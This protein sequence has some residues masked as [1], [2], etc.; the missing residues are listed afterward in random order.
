MEAAMEQAA[1]RPDKRMLR[2]RRDIDPT[3]EER[4]VVDACARAFG[5]R[6]DLLRR[7]GCGSPALQARIACYRILRRSLGLSST[8]V[9]ALLD[10][11]HTTVCHGADEGCARWAGDAEFVAAFETANTEIAAAL[12]V[13]PARLPGAR[14]RAL[15]TRAIVRIV[16]TPEPPPR[17]P[18][19]GIRYE[20]HPRS[21]VRRFSADALVPPARE[22]RAP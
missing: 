22:V 14:E 15:P 21:R 17:D 12:R 5:V 7:R 16:K 9:G 20:D 19:E 11:D 3:A 2:R 6:A 1:G 13:S 4:F 8:R 10:R 18:F